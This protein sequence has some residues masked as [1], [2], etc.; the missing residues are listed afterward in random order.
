MILHSKLILLLFMAIG[1][2]RFFSCLRLASKLMHPIIAVT[3]IWPKRG[4]PDK[5]T[6]TARL[7]LDS[8]GCELGLGAAST[9]FLSAMV[10]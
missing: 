10:K 9:L 8:F 3:A 7:L 5:N 1:F 2:F 4:L 6:Y